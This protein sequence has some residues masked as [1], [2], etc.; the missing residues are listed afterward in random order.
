MPCSAPA[1][2]V[3]S[4]SLLA[5]ASPAAAEDEPQPLRFVIKDGHVEGADFWIYNDIPRALDVARKARKPLFVTFRCVPCKACASFDAEVA[6]GSEVV[7]ELARKEFVA[8]RQVE[9][10]GVDLTTFEFDYNL[11]WAAMFIHA[12]GTVYARYGTQSAA[13]PDAYNSIEGLEKTM[14]RVLALHRAYPKNR[15]ELEGK[16]GPPKPWKTALDMPGLENKEKLRGPTTRGS[17]IHCHNV[18]DAEQAHAQETGA[19]REDMLWRYPLPENIGLVLDPVEGIRVNEVIDGSPAAKAGLEPGEDLTHANGQALASIADLQWVLHRLADDG[20]MLD[21]RGSRSGGRKLRLERG[22]KRTDISWRGSIW[23][24]SP[25]LRV[26]APEVEENDRRKLG[27]ADDRGAFQVRWINTS[28]P[29][30][31]AARD[32]GLR[33]GDVITELAGKPIERITTPQL[34]VRIKLAYDKG[35]ELP[36]TVLR[37][38]KEREVRIRLV[39]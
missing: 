20:A 36:L 18:H 29:G 8:V 12:D 33:D 7:E 10:K 34:N 5:L 30:G 13:G 14:R 11:N 38:G 25:R 37:D 1:L 32:A 4:A 21:V 22:W 9:M 2:W 15:A 35:D 6:A 39:E 28:Q 27:I 31:R 23:S 24:L 19:F 26:W 16:R 17:C 3:L